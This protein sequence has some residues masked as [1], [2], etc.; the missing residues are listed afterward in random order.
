MQLHFTVD[1]AS[2]MV[3]VELTGTPRPG[4]LQAFASAI[5]A[6]VD[7]REGMH[8]LIDARELKSLPTVGELVA[9]ATGFRRLHIAGTVGRVALI[10]EP[11]ASEQL[12]RLL[13]P[14]PGTESQIAAFSSPDEGAQWL[15]Q[16]RSR[17]SREIVAD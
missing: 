7:F 14:H 1:E 5:A 9:L 3:T 17:P 8:I 12:S 16:R 2:T 10:M 6:H 4:E 11:T 13:H 15:R